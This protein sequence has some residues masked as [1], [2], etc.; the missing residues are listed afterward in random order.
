MTRLSR[1]A[2]DERHKESDH[3][4]RAVCQ[5]RRSACSCPKPGKAAS[6]RQ[7]ASWQAETRHEAS[8][9]GTELVKHFIVTVVT[10]ASRRS[11]GQS[12]CTALD[13]E[14][15]IVP[16]AGPAARAFTTVDR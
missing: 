5:P 9:R 15:H 16:T 11:A 3:V 12:G 13:L 4:A 8:R 14:A 10:F 1:N 6:P 7:Q 2:H